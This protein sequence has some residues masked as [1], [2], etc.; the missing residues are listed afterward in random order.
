MKAKLFKLMVILIW[1]VAICCSANSETKEKG[2]S[3]TSQQQP[4]NHKLLEHENLGRGVVAI[5]L[6]IGKRVY[7]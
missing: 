3:L 2:Q 1:I 6:E 7:S 5:P 4:L